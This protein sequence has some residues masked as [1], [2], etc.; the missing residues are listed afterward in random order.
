MRIAFV[1]DWLTK[2]RGGERCLEAMCEVYPDADVF[3]LVH[4][5]GSVSRT[6]ESH[7]IHTTSVQWL[8]RHSKDFRRYL[9]LFPHAVKQFD[10]TG[11]DLV[12]SFSH[13]VAKG[14][15][16]RHGAA[17]ICYCH[18]PMRYAWHMRDVYLA[19][20]HWP[21]RRLAEYVLDYLKAWD[22]R[23]ATR[24]TSF[25]AN[26]KNTQ[27][28]IRQAYGR[29]SVVIYPPV[30]CARFAVSSEDEGYY[31]MVSALVPNK[32]VDLA[33]AA[34][35]DFGRKLMVVGDGPE[36]DRLRET[37]SDNICF[38]T[39]LDD[40]EVAERM[41]KCTAL[42]FPG[43]DDLGIVPLEAQA[44]GKAVIAFAKGGV[45]ETARGLTESPQT[46][47]PP[48]GLFFHEQS[49]PALRRCIMR[50]EHNRSKISPQACRDNAL[51]FDRPI[52]QQAMRDYIGR[53][54]ADYPVLAKSEA[55][56][57]LPHPIA[58]E[59]AKKAPKLRDPERV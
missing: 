25:I 2:M 7:T 29:D 57:S 28:R 55:A 53:T 21:R 12:L 34:F 11:Y 31:L 45:L 3:A 49:V 46:S 16:V 39:G 50:F 59:P 5:P 4:T 6:I 19:Q 14:A 32:R 43:E 47:L 20:L 38:V 41:Q 35:R 52:Y 10:L 58:S 33:V 56:V 51:R 24:V 48:T 44:C 22:S 13:C 1:C 36:L 8:S 26:S 37:A 17:H 40:A 27:Q 15:V 30:D 9:P 18:T 42:L 23:T 54:L